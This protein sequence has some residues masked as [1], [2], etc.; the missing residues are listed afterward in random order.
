MN[1]EYVTGNEGK[2]R[3]ASLVLHGWNLE[4]VELDLPEVQ[5]DRT[6]IARSKARAA[7][8][9]LQRPLIVEDVSL[10][11]P[12]LNGLPGP[13]IKDFLRLLGEE[14]FAEL[15][16]K[17]TN[18]RATVYCVAAF[19]KPGS[20]PH[21]FEG[22]LSG[23]IVQ[24]RGASRHGKYSWNSLF[25]ADGLNKSFGELSFEEIS[26]ISARSKALIAL[27]RF[28]ETH[29]QSLNEGSNPPS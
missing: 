18:H 15:I 20:E 10:S 28:L 29:E 2:F 7:L 1:I 25:V 11:C 19:I 12:A 26:T 16:H 17:Y 24:P 6:E 9:Q 4:Q 14:G 13:Y 8:Q 22:T 21:L 23:T 5:G 27:R 3:E